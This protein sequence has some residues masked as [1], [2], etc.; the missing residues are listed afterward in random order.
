MIGSYLRNV[1]KPTIYH[2]NNR[3]RKFFEGW[4]FKVVDKT[5]K[6][7][8]SFI[9][10]IFFGKKKQRSHAFIQVMNGTT[11]ETFYHRYS[12][13]EFSSDREVFDVQIATNR[14]RKDMIVLDIAKEDQS[15]HGTLHFKDTS[16]W[17]VTFRSPG[18]MGWYA[19]MPFMQC[20]H[21]VVSLD[22]TIDGSLKINSNKMD[23]S[24]GKGYIEKDWGTSFPEAWIWIQSNHFKTPKTSLTAS[25][26][27]IPWLFSSFRGFIIGFM[28]E[29][30]LY[31][32]ATYTGAKLREVVLNKDFVT[33]TVEDSKYRLEIQTERGITGL[34]Y[35]PHDAEMVERT[36][37]SLQAKT[38]VRLSTRASNK[39]TTLFQDTG[40]H[41][42]L[43]INGK[44]ELIVDRQE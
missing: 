17:P 21:G 27:K 43:D 12:V 1:Y 8:Y 10:G 38:E 23:F 3:K 13:N 15:V 16:P 2:G 44:I 30:K 19:Y 26:A 9:P 37:E 42:G 33:V 24:G 36:A 6:H 7:V 22:H 29:G 4:F 20:Y 18:I 34:L 31:R 25:V 39:A 11:G 5:G 14:F 28:L 32:F 40:Y 41:S 35:S